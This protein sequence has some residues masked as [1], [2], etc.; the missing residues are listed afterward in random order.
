MKPVKLIMSAFGPYA[1]EAAVIDFE[2]LEEKGLFLITGDTGAGKT[3]IFDAISYALFGCASGS[4]RNSQNFRS[5]YARDDEESFVEFHFT[6]QGRQYYV[7]RR[8][9]YERAMVR[10][11]GTRIIP[12]KAEFYCEGETP[13][14]GI[15]NVNAKVKELLHIDEKQ[16]KQIVMIAQGEF[17]D[18]LNAD[19]RQRTEIL[20]T[21]FMTNGYKEIEHLL[22]NRLGETRENLKRTEQ[23]IVQS[24]TEAEP[25]EEGEAANKLRV[26]KEK[27]QS[28]GQ[29][30]NTEEMM[31]AL[32]EQIKEDT[33]ASEEMTQS[34]ALFEKEFEDRNKALTLGKE[35]NKILARVEALKKEK[36]ELR[37]RKDEIGAKKEALALKKAASHLIK[38]VYDL[39]KDKKKKKEETQADLNG[40]GKA[41]VRAEE[42]E[43]EASHRL[44]EARS[45]EK[46]MEELTIRAR[47]LLE[48]EDKYRKREE[49]KKET[50]KLTIDQERL[51]IQKA[52]IIRDKDK[53]KEKIRC[54]ER[55]IQELG[56][57][58]EERIHLKNKA[59]Q[60]ELWQK[61]ITRI[62]GEVIPA[63]RVKGEKHRKTRADFLK[64]QERF[65]EVRERKNRA[66]DI[67][68][69]CRAG[70]L[71]QELKEG[72]PCPVCGATH[73]PAPA[74]LPVESVTE[75]ACNELARLEEEAAAV[76]NEAALAAE[77]ARNIYESDLSRLREE[78]ISCLE[79]EWNRQET[80]DAVT[81]QMVDKQ[82]IK[83]LVAM[84]YKAGETAEM[85]LLKN[86]KRQ[87]EADE[88]MKKIEH[89]KRQLEKARGEETDTLASKEEKLAEQM[90]RN[91]LEL[92]KKTTELEELK[93]LPFDGLD[94]AKKERIALQ[95][96][97]DVYAKELEGCRKA[98]DIA[99]RKKA[100]AQ[101]AIRN[102]DLALEKLK[103][104]ETEQRAAFEMVMIE[105]SFADE[106][107]FLKYVTKERL[108]REEEKT[109]ADYDKKVETNSVMLQAAISDAEG[110]KPVD[111]SA[112]KEETEVWRR[113]VVETRKTLSRI[114][115]RIMVNTDKSNN[116]RGRSK[117]FEKYQKEESRCSRLYYLVTGQT[118]NSRITL[119]QYIQ[120]AGFDGIIRAANRRLL[121][122]SEGQFE[123]YRKE[124]DHGKRSNTFLDLEVLDNSTGHRRPVGDLSGGES[125]KAA[126]SLALG[127]SDTISSNIGGVQMDALF[128]DEGFG[129]LGRK[130]IQSAM[131]ILASLSG[132]SKLVGII[133]HREELV[134]NIPQQIR[135]SKDRQ[136]SHIEMVL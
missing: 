79:S 34:L 67:L 39:W 106:E 98:M 130:S 126:L 26:L 92:I 63:V 3:M 7:L 112:L 43:K 68:D 82:D 31:E 33:V 69:Q 93:S 90:E 8:P 113:R 102:Y 9:R 38:P 133:S 119:E 125:F 14:E 70:I 118:R 23:S 103:A 56:E 75:E 77:S 54:L 89:D 88:L 30:W 50:K 37:S 20:R 13:V 46:E 115:Y 59:Q 17:L 49:L 76:K 81:D 124:E 4:R 105:N 114:D 18:L 62:I 58:P 84:I 16:F 27:V 104:E 72:S 128:V 41:L 25:S 74:V 48:E 45:H 85:L 2:P 80:E 21:I 66:N 73:H 15:T 123:L 65:K 121:P 100:S 95:A 44:E 32:E 22:K 10:R 96:Q 57:I 91:K 120:A 40:A 129:T 117:D 122:M 136:G 51:L 28:T 116:I 83:K 53:L 134:E 107:T 111:L 135:V 35:D 109:I 71:A 1:G 110:K 11:S 52:E 86:R 94:Q 60:I 78:M 6:H 108:L 12:E 55:E 42:E 47:K 101:T 19:T 127:L 99:G 61:D 36:E 132:K 5:E 97:A 29:V 24:F 87:K 64:A 131:D